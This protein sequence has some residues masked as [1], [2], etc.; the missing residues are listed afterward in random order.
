MELS[1]ET[2]PVEINYMDKRKSIE[3]PLLFDAHTPYPLHILDSHAMRIWVQLDDEFSVELLS[4]C[5]PLNDYHHEMSIFVE[6]GSWD[7]AIV[8]HTSHYETIEGHLVSE[9]R[10][11]WG[12]ENQIIPGQP[13]QVEVSARHYH[14]NTQEGT[15]YDC[16]VYCE[17]LAKQAVA[18]ELVAAFWENWVKGQEAH[19]AQIRLE[20]PLARL[21]VLRHPELLYVHED[22]YWSEYYDDCMPP[23][24]IRLSLHT[25]AEPV[26]ANGTRAW[27]THSVLI[28][29]EDVTGDRDKAMAK[30]RVAVA[31]KYP[32]FAN[33]EFTAKSRGYVKPTPVPLE[34]KA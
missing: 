15:E 10:A 29:A 21:A 16:D 22:W 28:N 6:E 17:I 14:Y 7:D 33:I 8:E 27:G 5:S 12:L 1:L 11:R 32:M 4:D 20:V 30:L 24:A 23:N 31:K 9:G 13:F 19:K 2:T 3:H 34:V 26:R 25:S 18:P